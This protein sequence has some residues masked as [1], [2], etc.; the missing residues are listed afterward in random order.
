MGTLAPWPVPATRD[1]W[2]VDV[3]AGDGTPDR[4]PGRR[5]S[6]PQALGRGH[7]AYASRDDLRTLSPAMRDSAILRVDTAIHYRHF[8][9]T[10]PWSSST[11]PARDLSAS[12]KVAGWG[13]QTS[14]ERARPMES[15]PCPPCC[16]VR[17]H[18]RIGGDS[19]RGRPG[20][21]DPTR[22]QICFP[23]QADY[24]RYRFDNERVPVAMPSTGSPTGRCPKPTGPPPDPCPTSP[25]HCPTAPTMRWT[26]SSVRWTTLCHLLLSAVCRSVLQLFRDPVA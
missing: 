10:A 3:D 6:A 8:T 12:R 17:I 24:Q 4:H 19:H 15:G 11:A 13:V 18:G 22:F 21:P 20:L 14:A 7:F 25:R 9:R 26:S 23:G 5:R 2:V 1:L 16:P